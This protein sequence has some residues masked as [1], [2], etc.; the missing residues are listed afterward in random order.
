MDCLGDGSSRDVP[1]PPSMDTGAKTNGVRSSAWREFSKAESFANS[2][3]SAAAATCPSGRGHPHKSRAERC[4]S[5][6]WLEIRA[7]A[8]AAAVEQ[9]R[10][11]RNAG[12]RR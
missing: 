6:L 11:R 5:S 3:L 10:Q 2:L 8:E 4:D 12:N 7:L 9:L 1:I